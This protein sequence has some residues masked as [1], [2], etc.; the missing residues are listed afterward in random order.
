[1]DRSRPLFA[2]AAGL[3]GV[4]ALFAGCGG[5]S[6]GVP[7]AA[8]AAVAG[9]SNA[10]GTLTIKYPAGFHTAHTSLSSA[11]KPAYV[12]PTNGD[13]IHIF[14]DNNE[15]GGSPF[16]VAATPDGTQT[17]TVPFYSANANALSVTEND[18]PSGGNV[19]AT[20]STSNNPIA[21]GGTAA[22]T[23]TLNMNTTR[24][25]MT[26][27]PVAGSDALVLSQTGEP[28]PFC[29]P[30][31]PTSLYTFG[32]DPSLGYVLPGTPAGFG[33]IPIPNLAN[34]SSAGTS[35]ILPQQLSLLAEL[36]GSMN[37]IFANFN[38]TSPATST[39]SSGQAIVYIPAG[40]PI[41]NCAN[42][43]VVFLNA[44]LITGPPL[45][46]GQLTHQNLPPATTSAYPVLV[47]QGFTYWPFSFQDNR[48]SI[49]IA[50][51]DSQY[52]LIAAQEYAL[53]GC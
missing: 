36:D 8:T 44:G 42:P 21:P 37:P 43:G 28:A 47:W 27:D 18:A 31:T 13:Y 26:S 52:N 9:P 33:G 46:G 4:A 35:R 49:G 25:V 41:P 3:C 1:M 20:G 32:A 30:S 2:R 45:N 40:N 48:N 16:A 14:V 51:Y 17:I 11:R 53:A 12:N 29:I 24:I 22:V 5:S 39:S 15:I 7:H 50:K 19:L 38:V 6:A 23:L 34:Q 10:T